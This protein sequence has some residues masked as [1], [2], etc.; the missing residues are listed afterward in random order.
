MKKYL[1]L[2]FYVILPGMLLAQFAVVST[3]PPNHAKN[4]PLITTL[5]ITFNEPIDTNAMN[6]GGNESWYTNIDSTT[7]YGYSTDQKTAW[8]T[9]VLTSNTS[10]FFAF[11]NVKAKSGA[12]LTTPQVYYFTTGAEFAPNTVSGILSPG[13]IDIPVTGSVVALSKI[14]FMNK[15]IEGPPPFGGWAN[16]NNDGSFTI[17]YVS[18][19]IYWPLA[20][21]DVD[22]DGRVNP[23]GGVDQIVMG[24]SIVV[25]NASITGLN[26]TFFS[27]VSVQPANLSINVPLNTT[28]SM[29][30]S[31]AI[32]TVAMNENSETRFSNLDSVVSHGYS[33]DQKTL[34]ANVILKSNTTYFVAFSYIKAKSGAKITT[35][36]IYYFTTG[37]ALEPASVSGTVSSGSTGISPEGAIVGLAKINFI[38]QDFD[39][40]PPFGGWGMVNANGTYTV[41]YVANGTYWPIASKDVN[42]DGIINP[43]NGVDVMA[44]GDS[45]VVNN[46]SVSGVHLTFFTLTPKIF[47]DIIYVAESLAAVQLPADRLLRRIS[48]RDTDT[49]GRCRLWEFA[50]TVNGNTMGKIIHIG[51]MDYRVENMDMNYFQWM[52]T[53]KPFTEY[54][55]AASSAT[56]I[57]NVEA[58]GG[59][60]IRTASIP[61][62]WKFQ[63]E[64]CIS[65]QK[66]GWFGMSQDFDTTKTYW[67]VAYT[68]NFQNTPDNNEWVGGRLYLCDLITGNILKTQD[69][70][71]S[72]ENALT[73][74]DQYFLSQNYPNPFNPATSITFAIPIAQRTT[75][76]I[77]D[78]LGK[79]VAV[80]VNEQK[81][82]GTYTIPFTMERLP[83]GVYFYQLQSGRYFETKK[84]LL[85]K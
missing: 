51:T 79:V 47:H 49:L 20:A 3:D 55:Q 34:Y 39:G 53:L 54:Q 32:D 33:A 45:I 44:I 85:L 17:P 46:A 9:H 31:E 38:N 8:S 83:S 29:T 66:N 76:K 27:I 84:M 7:A 22:L 10:Y 52:S 26:L 40:P 37:P 70:I 56:V 65:N 5:S 58:A 41:P 24:D 21:K 60:A 42:R 78:L 57:A 16:V 82:A 77:F 6:E 67:A 25:N 48:G 43:E 11:S 59:K 69:V 35:P 28:V 15:D 12:V 36:H 80:L 71:T 30:F 14:D 73:V 68:Y 19:G 2:I 1:L 64:L 75:L 23:S 62:Q 61:D 50:Y 4:V 63:I 18:N 13:S 74:P 81:D 72:V